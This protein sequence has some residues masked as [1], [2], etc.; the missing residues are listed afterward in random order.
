MRL[1][2]VSVRNIRSYEA[3]DLEIGPGTTLIAGDVGAGKTSLLYAVEMALFGVAE[4]DAAF[5]VRHGA[6]RA[7]VAVTFADDAHRY[8]IVRG[9]RHVRRRGKE[10][11]EPEAI[12]FRQDG[13]A[14]RYSA[15]ELRQR[16][17]D[18]LGFPD[19]PNPHAHS[20]L[21]R[22]AVYVPQERMRDILSAEPEERLATVRKA[23]GVERYVT[24]AENAQDLARDLKRSS[25][26]RRAEAERLKHFADDVAEATREEDRLRADAA[27][28][29]EAV[30]ERDRE[31]ERVRREL[32][33]R[34]QEVARSDADL[35]EEASLT[36]EQRTDRAAVDQLDRR[37][38]AL[39]ADLARQRTALGATR[40]PDMTVLEEA[41][42]RAEEVL[43]A[44]RRER[45]QHVS[46]L[47]DLSEARVALEAAER[48]DT[49]ARRRLAAATTTLAAVTRT[50]T[51]ARADGPQREPEP[52]LPETVPE[53]DV[54]R[55][56][57]RS[58][59]E[60]AL[61]EL[62]RRQVALHEL[63]QLLN[64]GV[65]P[66]CHQSVERATFEP[67]RVGD[68]AA[69][70]IAEATFRGAGEER[71]RW[72]A[73]RASRERFE[74]AHDRWRDADRRRTEA[75]VAL[76]VASEAV[77]AEEAG[78]SEAVARRTEA[79]AR[80]RRLEP[81]ADEEAQR[82]AVQEAAEHEVTVCREAVADAQV[83]AERRRSLAA[84][85]AAL[86]ADEERLGADRSTLES[87]VAGRETRLDALRAS[88]RGRGPLLERA[89]ALRAEAETAERRRADE[90]TALVRTETRVENEVRRRKDAERGVVERQGL[91]AEADDLERRAAWVNGAFR[92]A[93]LE[94]EQQLL[95]HAKAAFER[96][97]ARYFAALIDDP[98]LAAR[99]DGAFTPWVTIDAEWTP[100][101][102]LSGGERTS[103][104]LAFRLALARIV[105]TLGD[106]RLDTILLDEPTDGFSP[107]QVVRMGE[108]LDRLALPQVVVVSHESGLAA[109]ADRTVRVEKRDGRSMVVGGSEPGE[110]LAPSV[111]ASSPGQ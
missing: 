45:E 69:L 31:L 7:E 99:I 41:R 54:R 34:E 71:A 42:S 4:V 28:L 66:R 43:V 95:A 64:A 107:E 106:L 77:R 110:T 56:A 105:R 19:N 35:R 111:P 60:A 23:L 75:R 52:P 63:D 10:T 90:A 96:E 91:L 6:G 27:R 83:D 86:A 18:L 22:W 87:R 49:E 24:A 2:R 108:L 20:D 104:A 57:A 21:W 80:L 17:I 36:A 59:E 79:A 62:S 55:E 85:I 61:R 109:I 72:E 101:E 84:S 102:A 88:T 39:R 38:T 94:M 89:A 93:V 82:R 58:A 92:L 47:R 1:A 44:A 30:T 13:A 103:L 70:A 5:L 14:T 73:A 15:T 76:D 74:R 46:A 37:R 97:F 68:A 40:A 53:I 12:T 100:A 50:E 33:D 65:C 67:H 26:Q 78:A 32:R 25:G 9:F 51:E 8:E 48:A 16:V 98:G 29:R 3:A 81:L 11:F